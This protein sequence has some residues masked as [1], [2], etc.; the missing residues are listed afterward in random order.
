MVAQQAKPDP[1]KFRTLIQA[2]P[3]GPGVYQ[4]LDSL[5][6]IIYVGKAK[7]LK[8]RVSSYFNRERHDSARVS[9]MVRRVHDIKYILVDTEM[10]AL[11]LENN[12]IKKYQPRYNVLLKDD[13]TFPWICIKNEDFPRIFPTRNLLRDGSKYYGPYASVRMMNTLL[14]LIRQLFQY[15]TCKLKLT[16]GNINAGKFKVCLQ[17][18]MKNCKGP[19]E[20]LQDAEDYQQTLDRVD[21]LLK[22]NLGM[23]IAG[24]KKVMQQY[25]DE[26]AFEQANM[27]KE[28][29]LLLENFQ[30]K[31][32]IVNPALSNV[33]VFSLL[34]D[35]D[36][37]YV[38]YLRVVH[39]AIVQSHT[40]ELQKR[41]DEPDPLLM[42][43]AITELRQRFKSDAREV[44][45]T[46]LPETAQPGLQYIVP[47]RGDKKKL[48]ELSARNA[49]YY[50]LE[51]LKRQE[52][53]DPAR[54]ARRIMKQIRKDLGIAVM[55]EHMEC[56]D[57]SNTQGT[58]T[59]AAM[60]VFRDARPSKREYRH[61][62]IQTVTGPD[63]YASMEE[64]VYRRYRRLLEENQPLP[65]LVVVDG[66][67]GQLGAAMKALGRLG[68]HEKLRVIGIAKRLEEIYLPGDSIPVYIDKASETLKVI[69]YMRDEAHRFGITHHRL[70]REKGSLKSLL[71]GIKGI[72]PASI[73]TLLNRFR[74]V[75]GIKKARKQEVE[76][77]IGVAKARLVIDWFASQNDGN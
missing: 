29:L 21:Q 74:S 66:G 57:V 61:Y 67:K 55:P 38:N 49:M 32:T 72:G 16:P 11:L 53:T 69:Q 76:E 34:N 56:F 75:E 7:N 68:L 19:C 40:L 14:D 22:G 18:H 37:A 3:E 43:M 60:V 33:E 36:K 70:R 41:L 26:H 73:Q 9:L 1:N 28:K 59:V 50:R 4:F 63:D 12:L 45:V 58:Y 17:Y 77:A 44:I 24:L 2:L 5:Q 31:S 10:D 8:K 20:G 47:Q 71:S 46:V 64:V 27:V 6:K 13:K 54:H 51:R 25:A 39:G 48:L 15:R 52:L 35:P 23:V 30:S 65:Q 42:E 62:N